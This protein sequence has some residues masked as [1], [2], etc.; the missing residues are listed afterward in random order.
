M[1]KN[2]IKF[3]DHKTMLFKSKKF[4][5]NIIYKTISKYYFLI[6]ISF[7]LF[8]ILLI[9]FLGF[10]LNFKIRQR[11]D[12]QVW[13]LPTVIY[14]RMVN[15]EPDMIINKLDVINVLKNTKYREVSQIKK[16]GE[17]IVFDN[18][19]E[20]LRRPFNFPDVKEN[21][22][23]VKIIFNK[24]KLIKIKNL[25]TGRNFK[26]FRL[27]PC[28]ISVLQSSNNE[29]RIFLS[30]NNFPTSL[31]KILIAVE[32]Q[33]FY[34]HHGIN[35]CSIF[36]AML[37]N[38]LAGKT[39]QGG[40][41]L[42]QQLVKNLFLNNNRSIWRKIC[43]AYMAIIL[44]ANYTKDRI[45]ELYL[46]EVYLGH[47][48]KDQIHGFPLASIYYFGRP[49][50]ELSLDQQAT[51]VGIVKGASLYN[52]W[53]N[54]NIV[55]KRRNLILKLLFVR[56][57]INEKTYN[58]LTLRSLGTQ[59]KSKFII[60]QPS[61]IQIISK[62]IKKKLHNKIKGLYGIKVFTTLDL[63][64]Q[65]AAEKSVREMIP[66]LKKTY[67]L[68]DLETAMIVIDRFSGEIRAIIG[69]FN[70]QFA[71]YNRALYARRSIGS[72]AKP[73]IY[74]T[75]LSDKN[76]Y[77]LNTWIKDQPIIIKQS[78]KLVWTPQNA[79]HLFND[80][81]MLIDALTNSMNI[82]TI[83]L[84]MALGI[85]KIIKSWEKIG[86]PTKYITHLPSLLLGSLNLTP[87]EIGQ[88][89]QSIAS[90]GNLAQISS[91]SSIITKDGKLIY[92]HFPQSRRVNSEQA[93]YLTLYAMQQVTLNGTASALGIEF[94][95][96]HLASKTGTTNNLV[97]SWFVGIDGKD[98][99]IT[100]V[101][102][103]NN[104]SSK[105]Y[106]A[107]GAMQI[108]KRY[109]KYKSPTPLILIPP[110]DII[111]MN[112][113]ANG[114]F[115]CTNNNNLIWKSIPVWA[116]SKNELCKDISN[117]HDKSQTLQTNSKFKNNYFTQWIKNIFNIK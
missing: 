41:T 51:L 72:L 67:K 26:I 98:V 102:R 29:Q 112:I 33:N 12:G 97:D 99:T 116:N 91:I 45:L 58:L 6:F 95:E 111:S 62:E 71:G 50:N 81:V 13:Q 110:K 87:L 59:L 78:N 89:F 7:G 79:N 38:I 64:Y 9:T 52:P 60:H 83:N 85:D 61:F 32:D 31:I 100:W 76:N 40:S 68:D 44:D 3:I 94:K 77:H 49:I 109:L 10:Y 105:L 24:E 115:I 25:D 18:A 56:N 54:P 21:Q 27:D 30:R 96:S 107:S 47:S 75:A 103:D 82:P 14:G 101:G 2:H 23:R 22:V 70:N 15:L 117:N 113:D 42:T 37:A 20:I 86:I 1:I 114:N 5:N 43:E 17:F 66:I 80:R 4:N 88:S 106:G 63:S 36:R 46:N 74:L 16:F 108:Y 28:L 92:Q 93:S 35:I 65:H 39:V 69:G 11:I 53:K 104:K 90:G 84:G 19:I 73:T 34:M 57:I 8:F 48:G 55:L